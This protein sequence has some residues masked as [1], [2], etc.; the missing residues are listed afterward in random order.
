MAETEGLDEGDTVG[1]TD[2]PTFCVAVG[3]AV[4]GMEE[5]DGAVVCSETVVGQIPQIASHTL[6]GAT[7]GAAVGQSQ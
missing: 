1:V 4:V 6:V 2:G 5:E 3:D 7:E